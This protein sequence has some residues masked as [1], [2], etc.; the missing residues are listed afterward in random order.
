MD[1]RD[2]KRWRLHFYFK[3]KKYNVKY[4]A[5]QI[6]YKIHNLNSSLQKQIKVTFQGEIYN[7]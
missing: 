1:K 6:N 4:N 7:N 5:K 2:F 3:D